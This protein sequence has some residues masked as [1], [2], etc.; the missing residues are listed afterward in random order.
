MKHMFF[1]ILPIIV[2]MVLLST[3]MIFITFP[4]VIAEQAPTTGAFSDIY[5]SH[6]D[7]VYTADQFSN[8]VSVTDPEDN[9]LLGIIHLGDPMPINLSPLYHGQLLVHGLGFS[10]DHHTIAV[11]SIGHVRVSGYALRT[12]GCRASARGVAASAGVTKS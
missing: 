8:V 3:S 10:P 2:V 5:V 4:S 9:N 7:R 6:H 1:P 12:R 11:V